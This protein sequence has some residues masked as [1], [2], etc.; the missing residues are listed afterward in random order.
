METAKITARG[1]TTIPKNI[2]EAANL[3]EGDVIAFEIEGDH[4]VVHKV[5]PGQ[6]DYLE[7]LSKVLSEWASPEDEE[8][9]R[10]L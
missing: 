7:G 8:A 1:Q 9:W 10:D 5:V 3:N 6:D 2:R 4:L